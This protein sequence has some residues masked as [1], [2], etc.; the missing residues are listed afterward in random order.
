M[1]YERCSS[2]ERKRRVNLHCIFMGGVAWIWRKG[3]KGG[4]LLMRVGA[5][6][7]PT[8]PQAQ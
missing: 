4:V 8:D 3:S 2:A 7:L 1:T 5:F 6:F